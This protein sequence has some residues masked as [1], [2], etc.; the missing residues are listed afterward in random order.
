MFSNG[1]CYKK[2][3]IK[4]IVVCLYFFYFDVYNFFCQSINKEFHVKTFFHVVLLKY[5]NL[6]ILRD[7][8]RHRCS[9]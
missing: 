7:N 6:A 4:L 8:F 5:T 9:N 3:H 1:N 2:I